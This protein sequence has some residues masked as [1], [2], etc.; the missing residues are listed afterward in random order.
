[1]SWSWTLYRYIGRQFLLGVGIVFASFAFL[2]LSIDIVDLFNQ[3]AG[4]HVSSSVVIG[5]AL[6]QLPDLCLKLLPF[7]VLLGGVFTFVRLSRSQELIAVRAAGLSAW[8]L[9]A[10]ALAVAVTLGV[11]AA[12]AFTPFSAL[13]LQR[14]AG[15]EARYIHDQP[16]QLA[17]SR[18]GLWLRQGNREQQSVIHALRVS[19]QGVRLDDVIVFLY[20]AEDAFRG[21]IDAASAALQPG[22]W[23]LR[24]AWISGVDGHPVHRANYELSTSLTPSRIQESFASPDTMSF[25]DLPGFILNA[26]QA[27]FSANRYELY[28]DSLLVMPALF[29]AMVFMAASFSLRLSRLGGMGRVVLYSALCGFGIYFLG[30]VTQALG[31]SGILPVPLAAAAPASAAILLGM[32][33]VFHQEDG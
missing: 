4:K 11:F 28:F 1:M 5:M 15:L 3:T 7:A 10:P 30:D 26:R 17:V 12:L 13:L 6:L 9:L 14:F 24:D 22:V 32:S 31:I 21:R 19:Q 27:G 20:G 29:A 18:N 8:N 16:S 2:S 23:L 25:W 33:L